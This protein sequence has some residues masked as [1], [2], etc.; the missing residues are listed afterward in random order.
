M[1]NPRK[2]PV[3]HILMYIFLML[4]FL[5]FIPV[6]MTTLFS[7]SEKEVNPTP[8]TGEIPDT[9]SVYITKKK[10]FQTIDFETYIEGVVASEMPS[11]FHFE[12]LKAQAVASR[13]YALGRILSGASLCD[14][15]H[16]QVYRSNDIPQKVEKAVRDTKG[17]V[18]LYNG[19]LAAQALYFSSSAGDTENA[20]DV[21]SNAY[22]YLV[23]VSSSDEPGATHKKET[24]S[25]TTKAFAKKIKEAMPE[26]DFGTIKK[27]NI[28]IS[29]H[30]KGG[31]VDK[32]KVGTQTLSGADIRSIFNLYST[33][34][35]IDFKKDS[36]IITTS[37]SGHG[38]GMSQYGA[39]AMAELGYSYDE[40]LEFYF[41]DVTIE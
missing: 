4:F 6:L 2:I 15:V 22:P 37:G 3:K 35:S 26:L 9:V 18:L 17:Q 12:A 38:V 41:T 24:L 34:F 8:Y 21:F 31:R 28:K 29:S 10:E 19:K 1:L 11:S 39:K 27:I 16:C 14:T 32:I 40:I 23:S 25:M 33:R 13:T 5:L 30:T 36:I 7:S 20:E